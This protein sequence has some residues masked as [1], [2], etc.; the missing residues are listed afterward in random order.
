[1]VPRHPRGDDS[2]RLY[3]TCYKH[4]M[5]YITRMILDIAIIWWI[6]T[7]ERLTNLIAQHQ[8]YV[9]DSLG[10]TNPGT[11]DSPE[12]PW[13]RGKDRRN[14]LQQHRSK[15]QDARQRD[16]YNSECDNLREF[17]SLIGKLDLT[18]TNKLGK[19]FPWESMKERGSA[20]VCNCPRRIG[21]VTQ[22]CQSTTHAHAGCGNLR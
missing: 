10:E 3:G 9:S 22:V 16:M 12:A 2:I 20:D 15:R 17:T 18:C 13:N 8:A 11:K 7:K 5:Y 14:A 1:M 6:V 4:S 19:E 21:D